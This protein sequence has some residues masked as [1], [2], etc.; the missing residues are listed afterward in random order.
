MAETKLPYPPSPADLPE[1]LTDYADT[2]TKKQNVLLAGLFVFLIC[3]VG[4]IIFFGMVGVWCVLTLAKWPVAKIIG[5]S[6]C[7]LT[8]LYL[9]KGF[10]KHRPMDKEMHIE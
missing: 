6:V 5:I 4:A 8:F 2:F 1:G 10:F 7:S 9:V 3:Y